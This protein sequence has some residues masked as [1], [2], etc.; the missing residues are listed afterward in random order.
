MRA[1]D[2]HTHL[3]AGDVGDRR[4]AARLRCR[5]AGSGRDEGGPEQ[6]QVGEQRR[7]RDRVDDQTTAVVERD[8]L[9][10]RDAERLAAAEPGHQLRS[11]GDRGAV[12][13][14]RHRNRALQ[15]A[16][17]QPHQRLE[18][19]D[20]LGVEAQHA[21]RGRDRVA[22][23]GCE[24][25]RRRLQAE[26]A[27][28]WGVRI[29]DRE[30]QRGVVGRGG[31]GRPQ[32]AERRHGQ[33]EC[34]EAL[35]LELAGSVGRG[36]HGHRCD[37]AH[38]RRTTLPM[39]RF[40]LA[41]A[42]SGATI[43]TV[44]VPARPEPDG[45]RRATVGAR[46][47]AAD[48]NRLGGVGEDVLVALGEGD[49]GEVLGA[50]DHAADRGAERHLD[51]VRAEA[52]CGVGHRRGERQDRAAGHS[53]ERRGGDVRRLHGRHD[54]NVDGVLG[55]AA[56]R[57]GKPDAHPQG[58]V[59]VG[60][61][62]EQVQRRDTACGRAEPEAGEAGARLGRRELVESGL[63]DG[64]I[65]GTRRA[66]GVGRHH[67]GLEHVRAQHGR[68][69]GCRG[70]RVDARVGRPGHGE[71]DREAARSGG[72][73]G[74]TTTCRTTLACDRTPYCPGRR[75]RCPTRRRGRTPASTTP[76]RRRRR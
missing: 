31:R 2:V 24:R 54:G 51:A 13:H 64:E 32:R 58:G 3:R 9:D 4:D 8:V 47:C 15:G 66:G 60:A 17:A 1:D 19:V 55:D 74:G 20:G 36:Q 57:V 23:D 53:G 10:T 30:M 7:H 21:G 61:A 48:R 45:D 12:H 28:E 18:P 63:G 46:R 50:L 71:H 75:R 34:V 6:H 39:R 68:R 5:A 29:G 44:T 70:A 22:R 42:P 11:G 25:H 38:G 43:A 67:V 14:H 40:T 76:G 69:N 35:A 33:A 65:D 26:G 49:V 41:V 72:A 52:G 56:E 16:V 73:E 59:G 62:D 37:V 27:G